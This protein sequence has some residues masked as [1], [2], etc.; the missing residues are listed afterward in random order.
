M[1]RLFFVAVGAALPIQTLFQLDTIGF[2]LIYSFLSFVGKFVCGFGASD[3]KHDFLAIGFAMVARGE[4]GFLMLR[5]WC[6][7]KRK[8]FFRQ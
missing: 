6:F 7:L 1:E 5:G 8:I 4:L 3:V 2:G